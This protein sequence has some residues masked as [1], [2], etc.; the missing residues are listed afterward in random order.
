ML[1]HNVP[2]VVGG[3][4]ASVD[5]TSASAPFFA[6]FIT[7][8]NDVRLTAGLSPF[9]FLNPFI[10]SLPSSA[11]NGIYFISIMFLCNFIYLFM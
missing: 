3:Q 7:L 5:G 9:G 4:N 11:F 10:Y 6:G 2:I 1:G 8:L